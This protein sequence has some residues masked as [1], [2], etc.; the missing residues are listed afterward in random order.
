[1]LHA[2]GLVSCWGDNSLGAL[3]DGTRTNSTTPVAVGGLDDAG[4]ITAG[5]GFSCALRSDGEV[6]CW[7][8]NFSGQLGDGSTTDSLTPVTVSG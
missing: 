1:M 3:G 6:A 7:G 8:Y 5:Y 4:A 2:T